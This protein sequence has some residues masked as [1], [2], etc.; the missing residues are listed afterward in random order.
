MNRYKVLRTLLLVVALMV[1]GLGTVDAQPPDVAAYDRFLKLTRSAPDKLHAG[2]LKAA[3]DQANEL[4]LLAPQFRKDW[5]YGNAVHTGH[6]VLGRIAAD[7]GKLDEAKS[8]LHRSVAGDLL[9][10][11]FELRITQAW[12]EPDVRPGWKASPQMDTFG[13]DMSL[14]NLLLIK[15][16][17]EAVLKYLD[18]CE[19]FWTMGGKHLAEWRKQINAGERPN[20][21]ANLIY[22]FKA[23]PKREELETRN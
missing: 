9:P 19:R 23:I 15:G 18:E 10:Y 6:L 2:D 7:E 8:R 17:K 21:G 1:V 16:Q 4:L 11:G 22:F 13:P 14:A 3:T 12:E 5:N 20:F